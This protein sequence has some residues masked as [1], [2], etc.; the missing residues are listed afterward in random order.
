MFEHTSAAGV[1]QYPV[2]RDQVDNLTSP[3]IPSMSAMNDH[4]HSVDPLRVPPNTQA[5]R[6]QSSAAPFSTPTATATASAT[7]T[8]S[9]QALL[10]QPLTIDL[11]D[12]RQIIGFFLCV[13]RDQNIIL[14]DAE[15]FKPLYPL[16]PN[17]GQPLIREDDVEGRKRWD[18]VRENREMYW[19]RSEPFGGWGSG[20]GGRCLGMVG[21]KRGDV[22]K[23]AVDKGIWKGLGGVLEGE[24]AEE[25]EER[26]VGGGDITSNLQA[27]V[28]IQETM[29]TI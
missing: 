23:I 17:N 19:P 26:H 15:E 28:D 1:D 20:W 6:P 29:R 2:D 21:V 4:S 12:G 8:P 27:D 24:G 22:M 16:H 10:G 14:R 7:P 13:D 25:E 3:S 18:E 11:I 5:N 9:L